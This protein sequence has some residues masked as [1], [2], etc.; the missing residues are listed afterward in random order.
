MYTQN[1]GNDEI[2][3]KMKYFT[4]LNRIPN[5]KSS[6]EGDLLMSALLTPRVYK[7]VLI[8]INDNKTFY[9]MAPFM[10]LKVALHH[11]YDKQK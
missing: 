8:I 10:T 3:E 1:P 2:K 6:I 9:L 7:E 5:I 11:R 4:C